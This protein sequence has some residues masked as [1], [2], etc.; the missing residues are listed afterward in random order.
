MLENLH[1]LCCLTLTTSDIVEFE[2]L[3]KKVNEKL[4]KKQRKRHSP[5][6]NY[7]IVKYRAI[8]V[9]RFAVKRFKNNF[10]E[11][12]ESTNREFRTK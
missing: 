10:P 2:Y 9:P 8:Q 5:E 1:V 12:R 6:D 4:P 3:S 11:L 7:E